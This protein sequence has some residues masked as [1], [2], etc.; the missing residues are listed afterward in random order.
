MVR[1][2]WKTLLAFLLVI[3]LLPASALAGGLFGSLFGGKGDKLKFVSVKDRAFST[4]SARVIAA[5]GDGRNVLITNQFDLYIWDTKAGKRIPVWFSSEKDIEQL[6]LM[7]QTSYVLRSNVK[8]DQ[9]EARKKQYEEITGKFFERNGI[10]RFTTLDEISGCFPMQIQIGARVREI[11]PRWALVD[12]V[13]L[14]AAVLIDLETGEARFIEDAYASL[15]GDR[16]LDTDARSVT[17]LK[18]GETRYPEYIKAET[19]YSGAIKTLKLLKDDS[20]LALLPGSAIR[21]DKTRELLLAYVSAAGTKTVNIGAF[22][23]MHEPSVL[24]VTGSGRYAAVTSQYAHYAKQT[25]IVDLASGEA[26]TPGIDDLLYVSSADDAFL[27]YDV[28]KAELLTLDPETLETAKLT[29]SGLGKSVTYNMISSVVTNGEGLYF[30]QGDVLRG[31][32]KLEK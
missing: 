20:V 16:L 7:V 15:S 6:G 23:F 10:T 28:G 21:D 31:Y 12:A 5:T 13:Y 3:A 9:I 17:D 19:E 29:V 25:V 18:T 27:C 2:L 32:F 4:D 26:K 8:K 22:E 30:S 11:G 1:N 14:G 24:L